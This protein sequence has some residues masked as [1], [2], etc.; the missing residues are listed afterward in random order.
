[1]LL[2]F[3]TPYAHAARDNAELAVAIKADSVVHLL[4]A[5]SRIGKP[6]DPA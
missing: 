1:M 2:P 5:G 4:R 3:T 6:E